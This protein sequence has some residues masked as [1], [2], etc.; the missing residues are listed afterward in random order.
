MQLNGRELASH[1]Q[2]PKSVPSTP[3]NEEDEVRRGEGRV[4][5]EQM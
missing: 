2:G 5:S 3:K 4:E 1:A